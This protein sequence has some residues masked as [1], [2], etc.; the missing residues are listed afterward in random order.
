MQFIRIATEYPLP[1]Q[2]ATLLHEAFHGMDEEYGFEFDEDL[3]GRIAK[4]Y[5][6]FM[7]DNKEFIKEIIST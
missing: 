2:L 4:A 6:A 1:K 7:I 5:Y 3:I